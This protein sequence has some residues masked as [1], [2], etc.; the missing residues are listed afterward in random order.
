MKAAINSA[1]LHYWVEKIMRG[2]E[3]KYL[4]QKISKQEQIAKLLLRHRSKIASYTL[5][6]KHTKIDIRTQSNNIRDIFK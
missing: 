2:S 5:F 4:C 6:N 3:S 1:S